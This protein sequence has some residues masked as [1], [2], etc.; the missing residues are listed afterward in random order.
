VL[1]DTPSR[2]ASL[3]WSWAIDRHRGA[4]N[5]ACTGGFDKANQSLV[6]GVN[7][8]LSIGDMDTT[9]DGIGLT[10]S[11]DWKYRSV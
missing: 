6:V 11:L 8:S 1:F 2:T 4:K 10:F 3:S 7:G 5:T 9:M